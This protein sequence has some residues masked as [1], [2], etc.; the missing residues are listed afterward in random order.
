MKVAGCSFLLWGIVSVVSVT[1]SSSAF[2]IQQNSVFP[3]R[4]FASTTELKYGAYVNTDENAE[5]DIGA[6]D[7]WAAACGVQR[8]DGFQFTSE[9]G[10]DFNVMTSEDLAAGSPVLYVPKEMTLSSNLAI[11]EIG[12]IEAAEE[13]LVS[14]KAAEH[15]PKFYLF[16][17]ILLEYQMGDQSPYFPWL[18][19][20]PRYYSNGASMTPFCFECLPPLASFLAQGERIKFIQFFQSLKFVDFVSDEIKNNKELCKWAFAVVYTRGFPT[21]NG[22][23]FR[24]VPMADYFNHGAEAEVQVDYDE[25]GNCNVYTTCDVQAGS[26][27]HISYGD[28]TNPSFLF[29]R[30]GFLDE[31]APA[32]FCKI[33]ISNPSQKLIDM[34]YDHS[35]ML[36]YKDSGEISPEVWDVLL[37]QVLEGD[38]A[39]QEQLYQAQMNEDYGT[40][41]AFHEHYFPQTNVALRNHVD[42]FL[43][44]LEKLSNKGVGKDI[45]THPRLPLIIQHNEFVKKT[46]L[47]VQSQIA[48]YA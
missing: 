12:R 16:L 41:Q 35:K 42:T 30:Y 44:D 22:D 13:R 2:H 24:I 48:E 26:P 37:Y 27:L 7:E 9:D 33:M 10:F 6:M 11:L 32:T 8:A 46:F 38:P 34:G 1:T 23:D 45:S 5:R 21:P 28:S 36:F 20:L 14:A 15:V 43:R 31:S 17:K 39:A 3:A 4:A 47:A 40:K 25:E 19:S 18:N 29:A